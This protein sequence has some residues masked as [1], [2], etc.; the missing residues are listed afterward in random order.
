[1]SQYTKNIKNIGY[2]F[3]VILAVNKTVSKKSF[4]VMLSGGGVKNYIG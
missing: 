1:M 4:N 2:L 3:L